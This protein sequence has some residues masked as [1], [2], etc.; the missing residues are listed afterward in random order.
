MMDIAKLCTK[1]PHQ[2]IENHIQRNSIPY[3]IQFP[4]QGMNEE[5]GLIFTISAFGMGPR[6]EYE[7]KLRSILANKYNCIAVGVDYFG[8]SIK[9][10]D[11]GTLRFPDRFFDDFK[12]LYQMDIGG[13]N[14]PPVAA[15]LPTLINLLNSMGKKSFERPLHLLA[16][17]QD[18]Y[19]SFGI[20]P[21]LDYLQVM[22]ELLET[23]SINKKRIYISSSSYGSYIGLVLGKLA[24]N[25]F[26]FIVDNSA[27]VEP[28]LP[29][30]YG[31]NDNIGTWAAIGGVE[32]FI[33]EDTLWSRD[34][35]SEFF[36][37]KHHH[38]IRSLLIKEHIYPSSTEYYCSHSPID[39]LVSLEDKERFRELRPEMD[40]DL[41]VITDA[42]VDGKIFKNTQHGMDASIAGMFELAYNAHVDKN[43]P[44]PA[45]TDFDLKS[46]FVFPCDNN[47]CYT[48]RFSQDNVELTLSES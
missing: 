27:F 41:Q 25:T 14:V 18:I 45:Q 42:K 48:I 43:K 13:N 6:Q 32:V 10:P 3:F 8:C 21:A 28:Y 11:L 29:S 24:P 9:L 20:L 37:D 7:T 30:V 4:E 17:K 34:P 33:M 22:S 44:Q 15:A 47:K 5:T 46:E 19:Q 38:Q 16:N 26:R 1:P 2:D 39:H 23:Y 40:I 12:E 35:E 36:F 31:A